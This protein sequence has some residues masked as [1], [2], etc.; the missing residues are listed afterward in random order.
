ML[1]I[2]MV[3]KKKEEKQTKKQINIKKNYCLF[4]EFTVRHLKFLFTF[5]ASSVRIC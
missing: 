4:K 3:F 5:N 2:Y 1:S